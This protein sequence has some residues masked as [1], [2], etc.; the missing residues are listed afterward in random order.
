MS[1][2]II[3]LAAKRAELRPFESASELTM[4]DY[5]RLALK[6][7]KGAPIPG[8]DP[9]IAEL[10]KILAQATPRKPRPPPAG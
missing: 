2:E 7:A 5:L 6:T 8:E 3:D 4:E 9:R 10:R 1:A